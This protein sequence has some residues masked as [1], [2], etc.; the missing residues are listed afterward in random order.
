MPP[1][2]E[3]AVDK[4]PSPRG[5]PIVQAD[6]YLSTSPSFSPPAPSLVHMAIP[7][8]GSTFSPKGIPYLTSIISLL[9]S[10]GGILICAFRPDE[11]G[12][13]PTSISIGSPAAPRMTGV[14]TTDDFDEYPFDG[15]NAST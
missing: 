1:E 5:R 13:I 4:I 8:R 10:I 11:D 15:R 9:G 3:A 2:N 14:L 6:V 7:S 12:G